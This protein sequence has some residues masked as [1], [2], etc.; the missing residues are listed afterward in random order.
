L[1][2]FP[3]LT[4]PYFIPPFHPF[5]RPPGKKIRI[6]TGLR[7]NEMTVMVMLHTLFV[8]EH[9]RVATELAKVNPHW[10]DETLFQVQLYCI[11]FLFHTNRY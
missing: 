8:R 10:S 2:F 4:L 6:M 11:F 3:S 9:N 1:C 7:V 5:S